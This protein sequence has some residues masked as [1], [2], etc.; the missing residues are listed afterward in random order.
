MVQIRVTG[1]GQA[2]SAPDEA[3]FSFQCHGAGA[4]AATAL[5][6]ATA[7]AS[8]VLERLDALGVPS[9]RRGVQRTNVHPRVRWVNDRE[10]REGWEAH[11]AVDCSIADAADAF[12]LLD[13][14]SM[15]EDVGINGPQWR[16]LPTNGA[17]DTAR[18]RAVADG[19]ARAQSYARAA[20]V[21]LG[22]LLELI[23][24]GA[25]HPAPMMRSMAMAE[26]APLEASEQTLHA[27]VTLVFEAS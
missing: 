9:D 7:A 22:E 23:E 2:T 16:V 26:A 14:I 1:S 25:G 10:V 5:S 12:E 24:G 21:E 27:S 3:A 6:S 17:H 8:A 4:D 15:L 19:R 20:G 13:Q 11:A 18:Q